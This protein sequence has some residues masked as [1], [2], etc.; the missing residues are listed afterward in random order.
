MRP[1]GSGGSRKEAGGNVSELRSS[2]V[3]LVDGVEM[4]AGAIPLP[5]T[6]IKKKIRE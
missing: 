6:C 3:A 2:R 5:E 4:S 1:I